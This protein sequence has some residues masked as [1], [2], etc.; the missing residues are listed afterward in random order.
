METIFGT[1]AATLTTI[2][3]IPQAVKVI[4]TRKT[5][6]I[7]L[8]MYLIFTAGV[9]FWFLY[10]VMLGSWPMILA[11]IFTFIPAATILV[12]KIREGDVPEFLESVAGDNITLDGE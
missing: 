9:A 11:N 10:G 12:L 1:I 2:A 5:R 4:R 6:D 3:F 7:S 8:S